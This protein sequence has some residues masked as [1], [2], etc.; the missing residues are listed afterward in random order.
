MR[1]FMYQRIS[2]FE[3][4]TKSVLLLEV[5]VRMQ[6]DSIFFLAKNPIT[7][8][9]AVEHHGDGAGPNHYPTYKLYLKH[10]REE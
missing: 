3:P 9:L 4:G 10:Q 6:Y 1:N 2:K 5:A 7:L 8:L